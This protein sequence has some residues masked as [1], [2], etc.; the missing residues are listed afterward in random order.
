M[1]EN[2]RAL[3][4][5]QKGLVWI[6]LLCGTDFDKG[7]Y[8]I[9]AKKG[10]KAV[11]GAESFEKA[12]EAV[13]GDVPRWKEIEGIFLHPDVFEP[14]EDDLKFGE[15]DR[16]GLMKFMVEERGFSN[17]RVVAALARAFKMPQDAGQ[18]VLGKWM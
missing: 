14:A 7:V 1:E 15:P 5:D 3:G 18:G 8:G 4:I 13:K 16:E 17:E 12:L 9:G 11:K 6:G 2:L 10:F